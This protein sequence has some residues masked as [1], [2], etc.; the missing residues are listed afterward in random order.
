MMTTADNVEVKSNLLSTASTIQELLRAMYLY[1]TDHTLI[2][3]G[4]KE[5][6]LHKD[7][8]VSFLERGCEDVTLSELHSAEMKEPLSARTQMEEIPRETRLLLFAQN[9]LSRITFGAYRERK[10]MEAGDRL[11]EWWDVPLPLLRLSGE[12]I[13]LNNAA[14]SLVPGGAKALADQL[15]TLRKERIITLREKK[16]Y[17][18]LALSP[19]S[20]EVF[21]LE[22]ISGDFE[23]AE[24]LVWW[25]AVG[26]AFVRR[27][28][29]NGLVVRR[30]SPYEEE[31]ENAAEIIPC[32][33]EGELM[34]KLSIELP[35]EVVAPEAEPRE[36][37]PEKPEAAL[38]EDELAV[39]DGE[40]QIPVKNET[41]RRGARKRKPAGTP[42]SR[43]GPEG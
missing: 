25:A 23:M 18:T 7:Q 5:R 27:M 38:R 14:L 17:R 31:P 10:I 26:R 41:K 24:D 34:G 3:I 16:M 33:W 37:P 35:A 2:V 36:E 1:G 28:E 42:S 19:L 9:E 29:G 13:S 32:S 22:D 8:L 30:L 15:D 40:V 20:D 39:L 43:L 4:K 21:F 6:L 12:A 11:P